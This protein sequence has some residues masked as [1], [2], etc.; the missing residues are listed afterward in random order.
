MIPAAAQ[1][2]P[3]RTVNSRRILAISGADTGL[4][5]GGGRSIESPVAV[6]IAAASRM[7]SLLRFLAVVSILVGL[8][9]AGIWSLAN[10]VQ[11]QP[12]D[13]SVTIPPDRIGR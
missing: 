1:F 7:P 3:N 4:P 11:P 12:R 5:I 10:L 13:M 2:P 9:Y 6:R 8:V